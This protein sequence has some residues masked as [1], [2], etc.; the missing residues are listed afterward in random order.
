MQHLK[1]CRVLVVEDE[2]LIGLDISGLL[3]AAG[4]EVVGPFRTAGPAIQSIADQHFDAAILDFTIAD[5][6]S[7]SIADALALKSVPFIWLS[8]YAADIVPERHRACPFVR[9]PFGS[10]ALFAALAGTCDRPVVQAA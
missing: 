8:G 9:K 10:D 7:V 3:D 1:K 6:T 4:C 2:P 5:G